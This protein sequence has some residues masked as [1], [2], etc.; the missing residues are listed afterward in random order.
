MG[1]I[2]REALVGEMSQYRRNERVNGQK[3]PN[4]AS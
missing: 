2:W 4:D 3:I 1:R